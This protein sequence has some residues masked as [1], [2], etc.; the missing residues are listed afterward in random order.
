VNVEV[1]SDV[2]I[3]GPWVGQ[4]IGLGHDYKDAAGYGFL[5]DGQLAGGVV[6]TDYT[7]R[8]IHAHIAI[9]DSRWCTKKYLRFV[10]EYPFVH[11]GVERVSS[12]T[13]KSNPK[14]GKAMSAW[15]G[16]QEGVLRKYFADDDDAILWG[17]LKSECRFLNHG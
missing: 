15:G 9:E 12:L 4:K 3:F 8:D 10:S 6:F 5:I 1:I 17:L 13:R 2:K 16:K 14:A 7:K 11:C